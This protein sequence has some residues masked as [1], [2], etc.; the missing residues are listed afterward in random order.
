ML[1]SEPFKLT[2][3]TTIKAK[4]FKEGYEPSQT[5]SIDA[6]K[7]LF[8]KS[9]SL[10]DPER[11]VRFTYHEGVFS[12]VADLL[13]SKILEKGIV[14][15]PSIDH[16]EKEIHFGF[17]FTGY[18]WIEEDGVY[19]FMTLSDD[20]S[21]LIID[22]ELIVDNDGSHAAVSAT[23]RVA[24]EKGF[25]LYQLIYFQDYAGKRFSWGWR[26]NLID[27]FQDIPEENLF[28]K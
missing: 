8:K 1:Y 12:S 25:H 4:A 22:N 20:G 11:G 6:S 10:N 27:D 26:N 5:F 14:P 23:G 9:T 21:V 17:T 15:G 7:A 24:L 19:D 28:I 3:T 13:K 18:I 2:E 16:I